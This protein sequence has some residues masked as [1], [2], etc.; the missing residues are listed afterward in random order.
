[1]VL[2][3]EIRVVDQIWRDISTRSYRSVQL[4]YRLVI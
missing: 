4:V 2:Q 3:I 1:M